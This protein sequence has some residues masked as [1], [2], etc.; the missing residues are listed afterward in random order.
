MPSDVIKLGS[1]IF[2]S[3][4][5]SKEKDRIRNFWYGLVP[6]LLIV[7]LSC[8]MIY[9]QKDLSTT[10]T[11]AATL[12]SIL[13]VAGMKIYHLAGLMGVSRIRTV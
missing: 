2:L 13:F 7:G 4:F 3:S 9:L 5:L 6:S 11:L 12:M 8:G 1:I 10:V